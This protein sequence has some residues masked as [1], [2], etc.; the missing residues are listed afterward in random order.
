MNSESKRA[1]WVIFGLVI[2]TALSVIFIAPH[3]KLVPQA[4]NENNLPEATID[5]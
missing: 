5:E 4:V 3:K 1:L 2:F